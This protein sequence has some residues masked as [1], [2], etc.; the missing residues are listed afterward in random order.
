VAIA[1]ASGILMVWLAGRAFQTSLLRYG[2]RL[3]WRDLF[4]RR[5]A[6]D[7]ADL[8]RPEATRSV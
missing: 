4:R 8:S 3:N 1:C 6:S 7:P 5:L 2:Q